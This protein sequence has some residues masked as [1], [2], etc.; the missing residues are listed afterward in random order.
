MLLHHD[1]ARPA[2]IDARTGAVETY[3]ELHRDVEAVKSVLGADHVLVFLFADNSVTTV[4]RYLGCVEHGHP[5]ALLDAEL[6]PDL[7]VRL[8]EHY[9][10]E[11][12]IQ[13]P[14]RAAAPR[15]G[16]VETAHGLW[17]RDR[18]RH[19]VHR[20]LAVLLTTS[21]STGSPR[22]VRLSHT[23]ISANAEAIAESLSLTR[24]ER[25]IT[26]LPLHYSY[27]MSV[28]HSHLIAGASVVVGKADLFSPAFWESLGELGVTSMAGVP[29]TFHTLQRVGFAEWDLPR[30]TT[31]TQ[32]GGRLE[33]RLVRY[34]GDLMRE[35]GGRFYVMY[36]QTEAAPRMSCLDP[37]RLPDKLGS[38]GTALAGGELFVRAGDDGPAR[39]GEVGTV[40]YRGPNVMMG[41]AE[42]RAD[43]A[44]G[45]TTGDVLDTGDLG[46]I[47]ED[48]Y[49]FVTGRTKRIAK[50]SGVRV[51]LDEIEAMLA[52]HG[53]AR[54]VALSGEQ[55][56]IY[57]TW[58]DDQHFA[59]VRRELCRVLKVP[60]RSLRFVHVD[61][62]PVL[63]NGKPDYRALAERGLEPTGRCT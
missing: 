13:P 29:L 15:D 33:D 28:L 25:A 38:V 45:D 12:V 39:P 34:F 61:A 37:D 36:G 52:D 42:N 8:L 18:P 47:D 14:D 10:P 35:R 48:G 6:D 40:C 20:D 11:I 27:G 62:L 41:Y 21:G 43:L 26:S 63:P 58:G 53:P 31:L 51:S 24:A 46:F 19:Q 16:Y 57:C 9:Q 3:A 22:F 32:A 2:L 44:L 50:L 1:D 30:L 60:P 54:V 5:V 4:L 56:G 49:L 23:N 59:A 7:A 55:L 17:R